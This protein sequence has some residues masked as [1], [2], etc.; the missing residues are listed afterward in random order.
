MKVKHLCLEGSE[1]KMNIPKYAECLY[2]TLVH[3]T[4][5]PIQTCQIHRVRALSY[6]LFQQFTNIQAAKAQI[7]MCEEVIDKKDESQYQQA[8][9]FLQVDG[10]APLEEINLAITLE[11]T[12]MVPFASLFWRDLDM[13]NSYTY[14]RSDIDTEPL[15]EPEGL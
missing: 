4:P 12:E 5:S 6:N 15:E 8:A 7:T 11:I 2:T 1:D 14:S 9:G 3:Q 10:V 13:D